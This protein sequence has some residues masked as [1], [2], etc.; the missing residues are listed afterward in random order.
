MMNWGVNV[1]NR[2]VGIANRRG[3]MPPAVKRR[4]VTLAAAAS[5]L[6]CVATVALW[7]RSYWRA[8]ELSY[9]KFDDQ[10]Y[11]ALEFRC[12]MGEFQVASV[13]YAIPQ[14]VKAIGKSWSVHSRPARAEHK[15]RSDQNEDGMTVSSSGWFFG[16][17][18][19]SQT[20]PFLAG[21]SLRAVA[22]PAWSLALFFTV[23][24]ALRLRAIRHGSRRRRVGECMGCGYDLRAT[25]DR[26]PECGAAP[27]A[28][29]AR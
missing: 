17:G 4:L 19:L 20:A 18:Y 10:T 23:A 13:T 25:P 11:Q 15:L 1:L 29:A 8:E 28:P 2:R 27:A 24:P 21:Y 7:V 26:C 16:F 5:L 6:L 3:S 9:G 22:I 12:V 14:D